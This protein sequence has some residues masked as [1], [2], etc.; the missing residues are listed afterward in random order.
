M[1]KLYIIKMISQNNNEDEP[2][3]I[4]NLKK[5][6]L[7]GELQHKVFLFLIFLKNDSIKQMILG[8]DGCYF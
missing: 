7:G 3:Q 2:L 6:P 8:M 4:I 1:S 5:L